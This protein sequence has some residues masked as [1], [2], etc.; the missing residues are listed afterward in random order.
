MQ[1]PFGLQPLPPLQ[2]P[3]GYG[4]PFALQAL[5]APGTNWIPIVAVAV[6]VFAL[7]LLVE[8]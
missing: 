2:P 4:S 7:L 8:A 1:P 6:G 5:Q 3:P